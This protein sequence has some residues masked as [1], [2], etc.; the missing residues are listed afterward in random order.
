[1]RYAPAQFPATIVRTRS[2]GDFLF[3]ETR[4][5][6]DSLLPSHAHERACLAVVIDG[7]FDESAGGARRVLAPESVIVRPSGEV[8]CDRVAGD[9]RCLNIELPRGFGVAPAFRSRDP[10]AAALCNAFERG[11]SFSIESLILNVVTGRVPPD[12]LMAV[13]KRLHDSAGERMTLSDFADF[14]GVH[15]VHLAATFHRYYGVPVATYLRGVRI[16]VACRQ[17]AESDA[18]IADIAFAA[19]FA[20]QSHF[21]RTLKHFAG[22]TPAQFRADSRAA[23]P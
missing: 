23:A 11:E 21:G 6:R 2:I 22:K 20:D 10:L 8:H 4:Y 13:R 17:L 14:A 12:W 7:T 16:D 15:P 19:G 3:T 9:G 5:G 18:P 1:M